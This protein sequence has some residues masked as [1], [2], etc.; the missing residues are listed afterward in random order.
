[1]LEVGETGED[2]KQGVEWWDIVRETLA[3]KVKFLKLS[4]FTQILALHFQK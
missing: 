3:W 2:K 1:M 4:H